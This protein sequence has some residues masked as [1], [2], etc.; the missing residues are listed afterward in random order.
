MGEAM[1]NCEV[2]TSGSGDRPT[3]T[4]HRLVATARG[5]RLCLRASCHC[6]VLAWCHRGLQMHRIASH[7]VRNSDSDS[8]IENDSDSEND[9]HSDSENDSE[10]D[11]DSDSTMVLMRR[12]LMR[13]PQSW[14][15]GGEDMVAS[16]TLTALRYAGGG[17]ACYCSDY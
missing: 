1:T 5:Q 8:D 13:R 6:C 12:V 7:R 15:A 17:P 16:S 14:A 9:G 4:G 3:M 11:G 10:N 2:D